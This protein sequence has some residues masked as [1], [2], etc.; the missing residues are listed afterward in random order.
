[1]SDDW[2]VHDWAS[3]ES[4]LTTVILPASMRWA[5]DPIMPKLSKSVWR[6]SCGGKA[7]IGRPACPW[8]RSPIHWSSEGL[9]QP[10]SSTFT[11]LWSAAARSS[12]SGMDRGRRATQEREVGALHDVALG[13]DRGRED[14]GHPLV[15]DDEVPKAGRDLVVLQAVGVAVL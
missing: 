12:W 9:C 2:F 5:T 1:M 15:M 3:T 14:A 10:C 8:T 13:A 7:T 6:P 11:A 4:T